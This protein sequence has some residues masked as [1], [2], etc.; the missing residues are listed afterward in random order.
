[1]IHQTIP[2][3]AG[4]RVNGGAAVHREGAGHAEDFEGIFVAVALE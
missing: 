1:M 4:D 2:V 3:G